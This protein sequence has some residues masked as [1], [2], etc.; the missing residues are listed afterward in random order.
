MKKRKGPKTLEDKVNDVDSY[1]V[2]E[3]RSGTVEQAKE[4]LLK[5]AKYETE[6]EEAKKDDEDLASKREALK[7]ANQT[8]SEPLKAIKLK[9]AFALKVIAEKGQ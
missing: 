9:R 5:L 2:E 4:K 1:F 8:Y 6:L 3:L 7:I